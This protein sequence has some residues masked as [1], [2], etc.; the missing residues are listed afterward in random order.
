LDSL[1]SCA[2]RWPSLVVYSNMQF[3]ISNMQSRLIKIR[4]TASPVSQITSYLFS[5]EKT[6]SNLLVL[7]LFVKTAKKSTATA[8]PSQ[9]L[10]IH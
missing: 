3:S 6:C 8:S 5:G 7:L 4:L 2:V 9:N 1:F 10:K